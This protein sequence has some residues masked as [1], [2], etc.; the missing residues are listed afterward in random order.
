[1]GGKS[2]QGTK[3]YWYGMDVMFSVCR[4]PVNELHEVIVGERSAW[5][6]GGDL[7]LVN[8]NIRI[9]EQK[10]FG[11]KE[12]E[13]GVYGDMYI[14][15]GKA[16]QEKFQSWVTSQ[17]NATAY[18]GRLTLSFVDFTWS[19]NNPYLKPVWARVRRTTEGWDVDGGPWYPE[20]LSIIGDSIYIGKPTQIYIALD[21]SGSMAGA[22]VDTLKS[23]MSIVFDRL[24]EVLDNGVTIDL[25]LQV[26]S[27]TH[28][29]TSSEEGGLVDLQPF[30][31]RVIAM[32][33]AGGTN[34]LSAYF[35]AGV[36]K[37]GDTGNRILVTVSDGVMTNVAEA[38]A[39]EVGDMVNDDVAPYSTIDGDD[40]QMRG[41]GIGTVGSLESFHNGDDPVPV[42]DGSNI[43]EMADT[44]LAA[45]GS[46]I[47]IEHMNPAHI[48]YQVLTDREI[49]LGYPTTDIDDASFTYAADILHCEDFG[50]S[51]LLDDQSAND[52]ISEILDHINGILRLNRDTGKFELKLIRSDYITEGGLFTPNTTKPECTVTPPVDTIIT[53]DATNVVELSSFERM[54]PAETFNQLVIEYMDADE[55]SRTVVVENL[56]SIQGQGA[57][58]QTTK[59]YRGIHSDDL[60]ARVGQRDLNVLSSPLSKVTLKCNRDASGLI[61]GDVVNFSWPELGIGASYFRVITVNTGSQLNGTVTVNMVED[62]FGLPSVSY[63]NNSGGDWEEESPYP[64]PAFS[65]LVFEV[66]YYSLVQLLSAADLGAVTPTYGYAAM[67]VSRS[68]QSYMFAM[69]KSP[70]DVTY[71]KVAEGQFDPSAA[72]VAPVGYLDTTLSISDMIDGDRIRYDDANGYLILDDEYMAVVSWDDGLNTVTVRRGVLDSVPK[73]HSVG[74]RLYFITSSTAFDQT[75]QLMG[76]INYYKALPIKGAGALNL[77]QAQT[78]E[79]TMDNRASKP[80]PPGTFKIADQYYPVT[81]DIGAG[82][83]L[84]WASRNR[85][86]QTAGLIDYAF[87]NIT[88]EALTTYQVLVYD[89]DLDILVG[90]YDT[91]VDLTWTYTLTDYTNHG[92]PDNVRFVVSTF[93][94][95][96]ESWQSHDVTIEVTGGDAGF[97]L[98]FGLNFGYTA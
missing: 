49:G 35:N 41:I 44:I 72:L 27:D 40:V 95:G 50:I 86:L 61:Q 47:Q 4:G 9:T 97:G 84:T 76:D 23:A 43:T 79:L 88:P 63:T 17:P 59:T 8:R 54:T 28:D 12:R 34:A 42:L 60:A 96:L 85:L 24:Q 11:G 1:M 69:N 29:T 38:L 56:A 13:G 57:T 89:A 14:A 18:R 51:I 10:L 70:D 90:T 45:I 7:S 91:I 15:S 31:D 82:I 22:K 64:L 81:V 48:I 16:T 83:V 39:T 2:E 32:S 65:S 98:G 19:A 62:V 21:N 68:D 73:P 78:V 52:F 26:W 3:G 58:I 33:P 66:P 55:N 94:D 30:R 46:T 80:Y 36:F 75:E 5:S 77:S 20:K 93:V 53:L 37:S 6:Q 67:T 87:G 74:A 25:T 92:S 71:S